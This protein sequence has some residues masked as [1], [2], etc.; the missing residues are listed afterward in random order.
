MEPA[1]Q[2]LIDQRGVDRFRAIG[3]EYLEKL[4]EQAGGNVWVG[5]PEYRAKLRWL[6]FQ[7]NSR[8]YLPRLCDLA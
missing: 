5:D 4:A 1:S 8:A 6:D 3:L 2:C 7:R